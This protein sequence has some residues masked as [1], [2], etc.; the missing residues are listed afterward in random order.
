VVFYSSDEFFVASGRD[1]GRFVD[2]LFGVILDRAPTATERERHVAD[3]DGAG[4]REAVAAEVF[5]SVES[6]RRR[7]AE[8]YERFLGRQ[9]EPAGRDYWVDYI[10]NGRDIELALYLAA[11]DEYLRRAA[12]RYPNGEPEASA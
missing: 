12:S 7:V 1:H 3:L 10:A 5:G 6:R 2:R 11:S 9:P 4:T 8:L